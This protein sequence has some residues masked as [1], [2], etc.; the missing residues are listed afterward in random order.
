MAAPTSI[1]K[2]SDIINGPTAGVAPMPDPPI[3]IT[4]GNYLIIIL[5]WALIPLAII[6]IVFYILKNMRVKPKKRK[7][8]KNNN[9]LIILLTILIIGIL[10]RII[11]PFF[12]DYLN[13]RSIY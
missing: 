8:S 1:V 10:L 7:K 2:A 12:L 13:T 11:V 5:N 4:I 6:T 9:I 3:S